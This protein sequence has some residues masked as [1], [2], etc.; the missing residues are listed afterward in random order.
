MG[1]LISWFKGYWDLWVSQHNTTWTSPIGS[2]ASRTRGVSEE[3]VELF[4]EGLGLA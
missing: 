3:G 2:R 1:A 4:S